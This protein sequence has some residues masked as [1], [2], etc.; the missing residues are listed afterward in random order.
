MNRIEAV[1]GASLVALVAAGLGHKHKE[2]TKL[3]E[4]PAPPL[5]VLPRIQL[6]T[7]PVRT[8]DDAVAGYLS[9]AEAASEADKA[10][11]L[12]SLLSALESPEFDGEEL[13]SVTAESLAK[14]VSS[15][16]E[17]PGDGGP[18]DVEL[19]RRAVGFL[20]SRVSGRTSREFVLKAMEEGPQE[21]RD[22]AFKR[23]GSPTGVRG[24]AVYAKVKELGE[25][26]LAPEA[27]LPAALRRT[28]GVKA[29]EGI[30]ALMASTSSAK[31]LTGC[32]IALQD[33]RDPELVGAILER[34]EQV[35]MIESG[36]KLPWISP[37]LLDEHLKSADKQHLRR[38]M[39]AM[40]ARPAL[41]KTGIVHAEKGL[42]SVDADTRRFAAVAVKKAVVA[43]V[44][45]AKQGESLLAGRLQVETEPVLKA[46]LTGGLERVRSVIEQTGVQ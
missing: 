17:K 31:L 26:G 20:A 5:R 1:A 33:Y 28:G 43:K 4:T 9:A 12:G 18:Q 36:A 22:E 6:E 21:V 34:L 39:M 27:H 14:A 32:A 37:A 19:R 30:V 10:A 11:Q 3:A 44:V 8:F 35:G 23:V 42:Q 7:R 45:D 16:F 46:E 38:G 13:D 2:L 41:V 24:S 15:V 29:K 40:A 25:K